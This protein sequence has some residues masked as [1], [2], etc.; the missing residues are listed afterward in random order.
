M[1]IVLRIV[2]PVSWARIASGAVSHRLWI[3]LAAAVRALMAPQRG[4]AQLAERLDWSRSCLGDGGRLAAQHGTRR[5][6]GIDDI[7]LAAPASFL[8]VR[9]VDL[10]HTDASSSEIASETRAP[11]SAPFDSDDVDI[12]VGLQPAKQS[13]IAVTG[14]RERRGAEQP[15]HAVEH[16]RDMDVFVSIDTADDGQVVMRDGGHAAPCL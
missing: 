16:S 1:A 13:S 5:G 14:C 11:R 10:D 12:A 3:W 6:L 8:T 15:A 4:H 7:G 2:N 9:P